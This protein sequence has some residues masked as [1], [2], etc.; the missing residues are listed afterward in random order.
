MFEVSNN[1]I[2]LTR[3]DTGLFV[4]DIKN[5]DGELY[6]RDEGDVVVFT[7]KASPRDMLALIEKTVGADGKVTINP[8]DTARLNYGTYF[9]DIQLTRA[10]DDSVCTIIPPTPFNLTE[11]VTW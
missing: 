4:L 11:E 7:V 10:E 9:Y 6:T 2:F 3:G 5:Q 8:A 1:E